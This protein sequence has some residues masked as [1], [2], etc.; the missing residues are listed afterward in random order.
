MYYYCTNVQYKHKSIDKPCVMAMMP[1]VQLH[2][3]RGLRTEGGHLQSVTVTSWHGP[4]S[5]PSSSPQHQRTQPS[6]QCGLQLEAVGSIVPQQV[7]VTSWIR[8]SSMHS[9]TPVISIKLRDHT[10]TLTV[11]HT[12]IPIPFIIPYLT[13]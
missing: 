7:C 6:V 10:D 12:I 9:H 4:D 8:H 11:F 5:P 13:H 1:L 3:S 2:N